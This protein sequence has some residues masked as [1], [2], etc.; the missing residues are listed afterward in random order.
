[1]KKIVDTIDAVPS[2]RIY[3][4]IMADY[5]LNRSI[6][7]LVDNA[8]DAWTRSGRSKSIE[9]DVA[10]DHRQQAIRVT[11]NAGG[12]EEHDLPQ[13]VSPGQTGS[14]ET[15]PTIGLFGVGTKRAVV[16]LAQD[17]RITTRYG[18]A[19]TF[20]VEIDDEW[21]EDDDNWQLPYFEVDEIDE[22]STIVDLSKLRIHISEEA[23]V[24]LRDHLQATYAQF[25]LSNSVSIYLNG[26][27]LNPVTFENWAYPEDYEPRH[28][29]GSI[30]HNGR[31]VGIEVTA[32]LSKESSPGSGEYGVYFYCNDRLVGRAIK[33]FEVGFAQGLAGA[34]HPKLSLTRVIVS[35]KGDAGS[36]PWNSSKSD[37]DTKHDI[38]KA[39]QSW[40]IKVVSD[41]AK[42][43]RAWM[44]EWQEQ[45]FPYTEG[46]IVDVP[47]DDFEGSKKSYLPPAPRSKPRFSDIVTQRNQNIAAGRPWTRG[48]YEGV[49]A[50]DVVYKQKLRQKNRIALLI[51][52]STLEIG[53][54]EYLVH[55]SGN[56][57]SDKDIQRIFAARHLVHGEVKKTAHNISDQDWKLIS[58]Y[59]DLRSKLV[60]E[61]ATVDIDSEDLETFKVCVER[62]LNTL[63]GLRFA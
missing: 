41:Y 59:Y 34:P 23:E 46:D 21:L 19:K 45:V 53:F 52:D 28:Y 10:L 5:D 25:L 12:I 58:Y 16:A 48:L 57:Y 6:C 7:E 40:L 47:M 39:V 31:T 61:R 62:T 13:V 50:A 51:L 44:G 20:R 24:H 8:L 43:S 29:F 30:K 55:E 2:K 26:T 33:S 36:M 60:H 49:I 3:R 11:D 38:F 9:I 15:D 35:L 14:S 54:K 17:V 4:S 32:G 37:I 22:S 56:Y 42:V 27:P 1:M 63:Y 18:S